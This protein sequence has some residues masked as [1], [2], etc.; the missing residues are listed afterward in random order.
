MKKTR[1]RIP[2]EQKVHWERFRKRMRAVRRKTESILLR[3][4]S[5]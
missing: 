2:S 4:A 3:Y 5:K 1:R